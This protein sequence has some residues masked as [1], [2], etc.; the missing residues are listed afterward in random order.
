MAIAMSL[1][2][3]VTGA[4]PSATGAAGLRLSLAFPNRPRL[5][6]VVISPPI[7]V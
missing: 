7:G 2:L 6:L 3:D 1:V 4:I 5:E